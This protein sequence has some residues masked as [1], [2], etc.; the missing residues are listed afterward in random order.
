MFDY[1][2]FVTVFAITK[3]GF[4]LFA[5]KKLYIIYC[6]Y[7]FALLYFVKENSESEYC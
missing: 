6:L 7:A 4:C 3:I 5:N 1:V 2:C